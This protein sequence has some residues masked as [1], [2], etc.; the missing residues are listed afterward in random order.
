MARK[1]PSVPERLAIIEATLALAAERGWHAVSLAE[2]AVR[3]GVGLAEL[4]EQFD[5]KSAILKAFLAHLDDALWNAQAPAGDESPRDRL[6]DVVM[7]RFDSMLPYKNAIRAIVRG[8]AID[9]WMLLCSAPHLLR[10]S[11]LMLEIAG[12]SA[13]GPVG[14][15]KA[16]GLAV[17]YLAAFRTWLSDES[18]DMAKTMATLDRS[19]HRAESLAGFIVRGPGLAPERQDDSSR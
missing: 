11:S 17:V 4:H 16:K 14:R 19:L 13:T 3:A 7:Q 15:V 6:F 1:T 18:P 10:T 12:V 9:P 5:G 2:I 8:S